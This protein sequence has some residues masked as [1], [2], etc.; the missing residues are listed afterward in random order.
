VLI[1]GWGLWAYQNG[2][3][4]FTAAADGPTRPLVIDGV[5]T[6]LT[7]W[8]DSFNVVLAG[9]TLLG[10]LFFRGGPMAV[11]LVLGALVA[12]AGHRFGIRPV[13][14]LQDYHVALV[15]GSVLALVG[16]RLGRR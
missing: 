13:D 8:A 5:P 16:F 10:S 4:P 11:F 14:P 7:T 6:A 1:A 15:L 3:L 2:L 9:L 12:V